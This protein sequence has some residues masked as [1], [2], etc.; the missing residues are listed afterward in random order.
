MITLTRINLNALVFVE[1][2]QRER[3]QPSDDAALRDEYSDYRRAWQAAIGRPIGEQ[4][5]GRPA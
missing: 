4:R 3:P 2:K 5:R 1:M